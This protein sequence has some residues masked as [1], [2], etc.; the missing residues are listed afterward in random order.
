MLN[1]DGPVVRLQDWQIER[2]FW[3]ARKLRLHMLQKLV[4]LRPHGVGHRHRTVKS[5]GKKG[6]SSESFC[7]QNL[8][9][10]A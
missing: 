7:G 10:S 9:I 5:V 6:V 4:Q 8:L 1:E 3:N 2:L